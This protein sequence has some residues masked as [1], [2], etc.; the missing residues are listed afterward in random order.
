ME[1]SVT[2]ES[3]S[4]GGGGWRWSRGLG[5]PGARQAASRRWPG[6][7][8]LH[9]VL[10]PH[11]FIVSRFLSRGDGDAFDL[12]CHVGGLEGC[13][14]FWRR[15]GN[16]AA[17]AAGVAWNAAARCAGARSR[18]LRARFSA[19]VAWQITKKS[20]KW[21]KMNGIGIRRC[22]T[23][24]LTFTDALVKFR[25]ERVQSCGE[26]G[27]EVWIPCE[28]EFV[29]CANGK[30]TPTTIKEVAKM[31]ADFGSKFDAFSSKVCAEMQEVRN[32]LS[33]MNAHF[34][35]F[36]IALEKVKQ[37]QVL[38]KKDNK[39]L[40]DELKKT[41]KELTELKQYSRQQNLE[42]KGLPKK[43]NENLADA[44]VEAG[45]KL[46]IPLTCADI[47]V[48]HLVPSKNKEKPNVI[49][50]ASRTVRDTVLEAAKKKK[51]LVQQTLAL[52]ALR[53]FASTSIYA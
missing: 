29:F 42:I 46:G 20:S 8:R 12:V 34:E 24:L 7:P 6:G 27:H 3:G 21:S 53:Q 23:D 37:E 26:T 51:N 35:E 41:Q 25:E 31:L 32:S 30:N 14:R 22:Q 1:R 11:G 17:S 9:G 33:F 44:M 10:S 49:N 50:L 28:A 52:K 4:A 19:S 38:L 39:Q 13:E 15:R 16:R 45:K 43:P 40:H 36:K 5:S 2:T 18:A 48:I 47:D